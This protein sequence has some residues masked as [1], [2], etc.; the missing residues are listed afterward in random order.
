MSK[1]LGEGEARLGAHVRLE[2]FLRARLWLDTVPWLG[3][4]QDGSPEGYG[5]KRFLGGGFAGL[6][7]EPRE[8]VYAYLCMCVCVCMRARAILCMCVNVDVH[9]YVCVL[10]VCARNC[11]HARICMC[12]RVCACASARAHACVCV[13]TESV[14]IV[15]K[16][17][18]EE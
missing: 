16:E 4:T 18:Q 1:P 15:R 5:I 17:T 12:V 6:D 11:V 7:G 2:A 9:V 10:H 8:P 13:R 3:G 14:R